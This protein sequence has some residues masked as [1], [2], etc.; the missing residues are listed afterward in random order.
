MGI[1]SPVP[2]R[3]KPTR[4]RRP[5][6][7]GLFKVRYSVVS[8][9]LALGI[10]I[11]SLPEFLWLPFPFPDR[12]NPDPGSLI[13]WRI[14]DLETKAK[15]KNLSGPFINY[16]TPCV[17]YKNTYG[18][19]SV[20]VVLFTVILS[21]HAFIMI[22]VYNIMLCTLSWLNQLQD[23]KKYQYYSISLKLFFY[24]HCWCKL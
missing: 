22:A 14:R 3:R 12:S 6:Q 2:W 8:V 18:Q 15:I 5:T 13:H 20:V 10:Q 21:I 4:P 9:H 1:R 16:A 11:P 17:L 23:S 7:G 24:K 19:S